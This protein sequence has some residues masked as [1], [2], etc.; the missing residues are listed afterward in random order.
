MSYNFEDFED[1]VT[2]E[3]FL[4]KKKKKKVNGKKKGN[5]TELELTKILN[6]RFGTGFSRSVGSGNRW[7]QTNHLPKHAQEIFSGDLIVPLGFKFV[8]ESKGGYEDID[9][10]GL[11]VRGNKELDGF[12]DQVS[13]DAKRCDKKPMLCWKKNRKPWLVAILTKDMTREFK[14]E[15]RYGKW[16]IL[17]LEELL[18]LEDEFFI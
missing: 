16:S 10:N 5:R 9:I 13:R 4:N 11:F 14:Y 17:A 1:F 6:K 15:L 12:L 2:D 8:L 3:D 18:G 7:S